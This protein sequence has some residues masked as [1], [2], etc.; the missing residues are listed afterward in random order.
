M[1]DHIVAFLRE[2]RLARPNGGLLEAGRHHISRL[3]YDTISARYDGANGRLRRRYYLWI[4]RI[5]PFLHC[6]RQETKVLLVTI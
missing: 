6:E 2:E 3:R 4:I 1:F 5:R